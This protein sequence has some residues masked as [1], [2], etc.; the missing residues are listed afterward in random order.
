MIDDQS[1]IVVVYFCRLFL[2]LTR[3]A[4]SILIYNPPRLAMVKQAIIDHPFAFLCICS[5]YFC[6]KLLTPCLYFPLHVLT[7]SETWLLLSMLLLL[8]LAL[9]F[10]PD[11]RAQRTFFPPA[12]PLA[13][14]SPYLS[15]W[16]HITNG[17]RLDQLWPMSA[18]NTQVT[19]QFVIVCSV[20][21]GTHIFISFST[22]VGL[23]LCVLTAC[24]IQSLETQALTCQALTSI[25]P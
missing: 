17:T 5:S 16:D 23:L 9:L 25:P 12:I 18:T 2:P 13:V 4:C 21:H 10:L 15:S 24:P 19:C 6:L 22:L 1:L 7:L 3:I 14:R 20:G 11:A 8:F